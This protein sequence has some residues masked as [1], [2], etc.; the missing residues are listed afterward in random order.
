[1]QLEGGNETNISVYAHRTA[2]LLGDGC[3]KFVMRVALYIFALTLA[4]FAGVGVSAVHD[5]I[6]DY[7]RYFR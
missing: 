6:V 5:M 4:L 3:D 7:L 2:H 1:M